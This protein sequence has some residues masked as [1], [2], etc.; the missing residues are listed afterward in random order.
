MRHKEQ[1]WKGRATA[2]PNF[3]FCKTSVWGAGGTP[4]NI[5][6]QVQ[7]AIIFVYLLRERLSWEHP[8][9]G[10]GR[11]SRLEQVGLRLSFPHGG[12][13]QGCGARGGSRVG[14]NFHVPGSRAS[15]QQSGAHSPLTG[16]SGA[17]VGAYY[18]QARQNVP[19]HAPGRVALVAVGP[20]PSLAHV[21][22]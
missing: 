1:L 18:R 5:E 10:H 19:C 6:D 12:V 16:K 4:A 17:H 3:S 2:F 8:P 14:N 21:P 13:L 9:L 20:W 11:W 15:H 22:T 7:E